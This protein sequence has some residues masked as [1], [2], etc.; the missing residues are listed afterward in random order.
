MDVR[1]EALAL[2]ADLCTHGHQEL[3]AGEEAWG[4][5]CRNSPSLLNMGYW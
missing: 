4:K 2:V 5:G 3:A 1:R